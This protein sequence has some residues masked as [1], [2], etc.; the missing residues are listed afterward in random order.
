MKIA[1][2]GCN[3]SVG[4]RVVQLALRRGHTVVGIDHVE[5]KETIQHAKF[6]FVLADLKHYDAAIKAL[7]GCDGVVH[8]AAYRNPGDYEVTTHNSNVVISWNVLRACAKLGI[9]R[10]AQASTVNVV[11]M[12]YSQHCKFEYFPIDEAH[13]CL[14]DEPYGLSKVICE[15]QAD[16]IV[17]RYP[18]MRIAS[19]RLH[20]SV[21]HRSH[22][23]S[24][25]STQRSKDLWSYVQEDSAADAFLLALTGEGDEWSGHEAFFITAPEVA[26]D[27]DVK[28]LLQRFWP[29]VPIREG[30]DVSGRT[31]LFDCDKAERLLGW[32]HKDDT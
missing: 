31:G 21:P 29:D 3:G 10:I 11:T 17:R 2:T 15:L 8:L 4:K 16:T 32:V 20:W 24:I 19:L 5:S 9:N 14:P 12:V 1:I 26:C 23:Q 6:A 25:D 13:P 27:E 7:E 28:D 18:S 22:A 30:K